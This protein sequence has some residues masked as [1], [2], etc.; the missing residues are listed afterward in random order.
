MFQK[1]AN[2][3]NGLGGSHARI[4]ALDLDP[5]QGNNDKVLDDLRGHPPPALGITR[6]K[7][8]GR[9]YPLAEFSGLG[10]QCSDFVRLLDQAVHRL[11]DLVASCFDLP[12][13]LLPH[14]LNGSRDIVPLLR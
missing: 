1:R 13:S 10:P 14:G 11:G 3:S 9:L 2:F 8:T 12:D 6:P 5:S 7:Q 4:A